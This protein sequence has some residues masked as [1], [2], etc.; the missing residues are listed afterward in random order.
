MSFLVC[1][2]CLNTFSEGLIRILL[3]SYH[4]GKGILLLAKG[5]DTVASTNI[6]YFVLWYALTRFTG[7]QGQQLVS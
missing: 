3:F 1:M 4:Q 7:K 2:H 5:L 6:L